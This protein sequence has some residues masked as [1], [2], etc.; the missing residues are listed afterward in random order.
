[1]RSS[2]FTLHSSPPF[3]AFEPY[4]L[5]RSF[6]NRSVAKSD[7]FEKETDH[8][9]VADG[10]WLCVDASKWNNDAVDEPNFALIPEDR[11]LALLLR[12]AGQ[13]PLDIWILHRIHE[14]M[15]RLFDP[16]T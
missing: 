5:L 15:L 11:R 16:E 3:R 6:S 1:M 2:S 9:H 14:N 10:F 4:A 12:L 8:E 13:R 7:S